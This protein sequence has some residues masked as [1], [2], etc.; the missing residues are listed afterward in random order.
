MR[1]EYPNWA[2]S[3]TVRWSTARVSP[4]YGV[5]SAFIKSQN[6]RITRPE[7]GRQGSTDNVRASGRSKSFVPALR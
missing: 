3:S 1:I 5:P 7:D 2:A 6:I 4:P